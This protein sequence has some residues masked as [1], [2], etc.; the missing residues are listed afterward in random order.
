MSERFGRPKQLAVFKGKHLIEHAI[1]AALGSKLEKV[2]VVL[3]HCHERI[4]ST[5]KD[6]FCHPRIEIV[7]NPE[8]EKGQSASLRTGLAVAAD[9]FSS[10][11]FIVAD[12]PMLNSGTI[13]FLLDEYHGTD[14]D[15]CVPVCRGRRGNPVIF[16]RAM[17]GR[18]FETQGDTGARTLIRSHPD[19]VLFAEI[20]DPSCLFDIDTEN[21]L[22]Q[23]EIYD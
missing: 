2:I 12:Q 13:D 23:L 8:Y 19:R 18:L 10:V 1:D 6:K 5:L 21:D 9:R 7:L 3:G 11:M 22:K 4:C 14:K 15:I 20:P 17:Y 16:G